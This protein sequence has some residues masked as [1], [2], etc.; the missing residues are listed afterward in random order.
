MHFTV[1]GPITARLNK[2]ERNMRVIGTR[3][4][5]RLSDANT[6]GMLERLPIDDLAGYVKAM[7]TGRI[8]CIEK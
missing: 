4:V 8:V 5:H 1:A 3:T 6:P 7:I 2:P